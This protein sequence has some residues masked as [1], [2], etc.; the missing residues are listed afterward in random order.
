M[1]TQYDKAAA[2]AI[3]AAV[4]SILAA[5]TTLDAEVIAAIGVLLTSGLVWLVPNKTKSG[6]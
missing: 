3:A 5:M 4:T 1:L 6:A 2:G